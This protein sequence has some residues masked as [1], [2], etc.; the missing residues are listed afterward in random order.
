M[1][2]NHEKEALE[3]YKK[4]ERIM[5]EG[6]FNLRK[7][8]SKDKDLMEEI[9][10]FEQQ[11]VTSRPN[12]IET[13]KVDVNESKKATKILG[14]NWN[15]D[16]DAFYHDFRGIAE[17]A[18]SLS[19]SK[20]SLRR[21]VATLCWIK[22]NKV[23]NP[24]VAKRVHEILKTSERDQWLYCPGPQNPAD[25]PSR[26]KYKQCSPPNIFWWEGAQFLKANKEDWPAFPKENDT[27][28]AMK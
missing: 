1:R 6:G 26:G 15:N 9:N 10:A 11:E 3:I 8:V 20:P 4:S 28:E 22:N 25:L 7:W 27:W 24:C 16:S 17:F 18:E 2:S 23:W 14:I 19:V 5:A 13:S 12:T 21:I